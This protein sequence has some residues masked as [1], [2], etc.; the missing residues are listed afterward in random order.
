MVFLGSFLRVGVIWT[1]ADVAN[2]LMAIPNLIALIMLSTKV[3]EETLDYD[4][5][6]IDQKPVTEVSES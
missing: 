6:S 4:F 1:I 5:K 3:K 2:A